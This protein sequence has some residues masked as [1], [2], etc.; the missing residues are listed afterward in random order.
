MPRKQQH[1]YETETKIFPTKL[2][3]LMEERRWTQLDVASRIGMQRQTVAN[4]KS[5]Q[6]SPDVE[7]LVKIADAFDVSVDYLVRDNVPRTRDT[8]IKD[9]CD[10]TGLSED[11]VNVLHYIRSKSGSPKDD[12]AVANR[13]NVSFINRVLGMCAKYA[14][15]DE[16]GDTRAIDTILSLMERYITIKNDSTS[17]RIHGESGSEN[18]KIVTIDFDGETLGVTS[19]EVASMLLKT[20][21]DKA[22][23]RLAEKENEK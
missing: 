15:D 11:A 7:A 6:S 4:Y 2:R 1:A 23:D 18:A 22:L 12:A 19:H 20:R 14:S 21:I 16:E 3:E 9:I 10:Y 5:G 17:I 13:L 8:K